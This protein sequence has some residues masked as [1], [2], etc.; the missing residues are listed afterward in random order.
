MEIT[1]CH[2]KMSKSTRP[3]TRLNFIRNQRG[4]FYS[5]KKSKAIFIT[6]L[7]ISI[8]MTGIG[9]FLSSCLIPVQDLDMVSKSEMI[10]LAKNC[11]I[12]YSLGNVMYHIG[13]F[14]FF[15]CLISLIVR[16]VYRI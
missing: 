12:N 16:I 1:S 11:S 14:L 15:M 8:L 6:G 3:N 2:M 13:V 9:T 4:K 5:M 7:T 10:E